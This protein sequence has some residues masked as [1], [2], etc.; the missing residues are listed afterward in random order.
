LKHSG[1]EETRAAKNS[2]IDPFDY[3]ISLLFPERCL[4]CREILP[5]GETFAL[6]ASCHKNFVP[7]G[8]I[9]PVC[10]HPNSRG[11]ECSCPQSLSPLS[12]LVALTWYDR[13]WRQLLHDLKYRKRRSL[14]RPF[15]RW[16]GREIIRQAFCEPDLVV[17][18]PLHRCREKERG[19]NQSA[20]IGRHTAAVLG[21]PCRQILS[22]IRHT[23]SQTT[24]SRRE[25]RENV[26]GAFGTVKLPPSGS[27]ILLI[28]DIYSTGATMKEAAALLRKSGLTVHGA[29]I[30]YNPRF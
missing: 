30:A 28:D 8:R 15:G 9:C 6:C 12:S 14:A 25:R 1:R 2:P 20:L 27:T 19:F 16:L 26:R 21:V 4:S 23:Q 13:Q 18:I 22:K 17:P 11:A 7:A 3:F 29:V 5:P 10:E 24:I